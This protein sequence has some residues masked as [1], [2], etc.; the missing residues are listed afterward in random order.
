MATKRPQL[1]LVELGEF[2]DLLT[3]ALVDKVRLPLLLLMVYRKK[4]KKK[5][6]KNWSFAL[7]APSHGRY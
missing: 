7:A 2:D 4:K 6:K 1:S 3:D 5:K